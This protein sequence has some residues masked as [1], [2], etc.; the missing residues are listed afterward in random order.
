MTLK[1]IV[2]ASR[3]GKGRRRLLM[4]VSAAGVVLALAGQRLPGVRMDMGYA[5]SRVGGD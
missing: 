2:P 5:R 1:P 3:W 4:G